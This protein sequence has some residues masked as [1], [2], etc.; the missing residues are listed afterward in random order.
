M[1]S[2]LILYSLKC[3]HAAPAPATLVSGSLECAW[4]HKVSTISGVITWEWCAKCVDCSYIRWAGLSKYNTGI[5]ANGHVR[6]YPSHTVMS[7][8]RENPDAVAT[9]DKFEAWQGR[10]PA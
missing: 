7:E 10:K 8:Y 2:R 6:R 9:A 5:M 3:G 1:N 4:C